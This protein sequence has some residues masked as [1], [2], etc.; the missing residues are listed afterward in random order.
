MQI[1]L[2]KIKFVH[3]VQQFLIISAL[4]KS[5]FASKQLEFLEIV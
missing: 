5:Y 2:L 3:T 4:V 1:K